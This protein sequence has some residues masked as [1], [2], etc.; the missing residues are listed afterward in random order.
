MKL[1]LKAGA[2]LPFAHLLGM[3]KTAAKAEDDE[4][5]DDEEDDKKAKSKKADSDEPKER[6]EDEDARADSDDADANASAEDDEGDDGEDKKKD[7]DEADDED[8][9]KGSKARSARLRERARCAAIFMDEA[10]GKNPALAATLAFNT[11]MPR[12]Q[13]ITVLRAGGAAVQPKRDS[14]DRRMSSIPRPNVGAGDTI[15]SKASFADRALAASKKARGE[16]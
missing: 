7:D 11:D 16:A 8:M 13:A 10:A 9:K 2:A 15:A 1:N 3:S 6:D 14:L 4:P 5:H 12:S